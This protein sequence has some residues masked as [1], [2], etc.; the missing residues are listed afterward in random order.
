M[1]GRGV[2]GQAQALAQALAK[3]C[4]VVVVVRL[5]EWNVSLSQLMNTPDKVMAHYFTPTVQR[6]GPI[7]RSVPILVVI[8]FILSQ[9]PLVIG[10]V[11]I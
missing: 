9:M 3:E 8:H 1:E 5:C 7:K 2:R 4:N 11:D 6:D 10:G